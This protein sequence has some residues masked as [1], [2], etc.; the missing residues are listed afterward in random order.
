[1]RQTVW[2]NGFKKLIFVFLFESWLKMLSYKD[3]TTV[4][5]FGRLCNRLGVCKDMELEV[6]AY[7]TT[8]ASTIKT[9]EIN[10]ISDKYNQT[11]M[12][13]YD[14]KFYELYSKYYINMLDML[15]NLLYR[16][17]HKAGSGYVVSYVNAKVRIAYIGHTEPYND[18]KYDDLH[19]IILK[20]KKLTNA[21]IPLDTIL[22][23]N[24]AVVYFNW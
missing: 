3:L 14:V 9:I 10:L 19:D 4:V 1:M 21:D 18:F 24:G 22:G 5:S 12:Y 15:F 7:Y 17:A 6:L 20:N 23:T 2:V 11:I 8:L 16:L 13:S